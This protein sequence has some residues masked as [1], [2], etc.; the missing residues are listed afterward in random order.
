MNYTVT[1]TQYWTY[2]VEAE[3]DDEA[4]NLAFEKF[5]ADMHRSIACTAYDEINIE[6]EEEE[7]Y[8]EA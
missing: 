3:S 4:E 7:I 1:F 2:D 8:G 5:E 6:A